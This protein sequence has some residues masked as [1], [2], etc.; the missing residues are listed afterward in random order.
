VILRARPPVVVLGAGIAG[1]T[2]ARELH[3]RGIAVKLFEAG[4]KVA[5]LAASHRDEEGF[6]TDY[7]AHYIPNRLAAS[8]G[9]SARCDVVR[10]Y[11]ETVFFRGRTYSFP[12]GLLRSPRYTMSAAVARLRAR[13]RP[14]ESAAEWYQSAYGTALA[15]DIAIPLV[16]AWAGA[17]A[18]DLAASVIPPQA[19]R[20]ALHVA[21]LK[22]ASRLSARAVANGYSR[23]LPETPHVWHVYPAGGVGMLCDHLAADLDGIIQLES[24]VEQILVDSGRAVGVRVRGTVH[25]ASAVVSTAPV[26]VLPKLVVGSEALRP[27]ARFRFRPMT[28]L[29]LRL[30]GQRLLPDVVTWVPERHM[31]FFRLT[32]TTWSMPGLAPPG[33]TIIS[34]D[35]GCETS[36]PI[37]SMTA[38][39]V[40]ELALEHLEAIIPGVRR[41]YVGARVMRTPVAYPLFLREYE[42]DRV[43]F[44]RAMPIEGLYSVGRNGEFAHILMEDIYWRTRR[45]MRELAAGLM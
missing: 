16:E 18:R 36:D 25:E 6:V 5:G 40:A 37:W 34:V 17:D 26:H 29:N 39:Q 13:A 30:N 33:K 4:K 38:D 10:H 7:G 31:P 43:A 41:R 2:A 20:G 3:R 12:F 24:P 9:V 35:F 19:E 14:P 42:A 32:E 22:L 21:G 44:Q 8:L 23:D 15:S 45:R 27:L 28:L 11:G 1:L